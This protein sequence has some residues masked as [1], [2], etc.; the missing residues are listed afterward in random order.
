MPK[1]EPVFSNTQSLRVELQAAALQ[2][3]LDKLTA[4]E[5]KK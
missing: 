1:A 4:L 2:Q 5:T 3:A